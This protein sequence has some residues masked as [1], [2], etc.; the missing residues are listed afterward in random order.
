LYTKE[1]R[2]SVKMVETSIEA[3]T[4]TVAAGAVAA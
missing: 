2:I 4:Y 1:V 3:A